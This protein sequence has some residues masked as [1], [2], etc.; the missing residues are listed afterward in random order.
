MTRRS[1]FRFGRQGK[2]LGGGNKRKSYFRGQRGKMDERTV[3]AKALR[4]K[5]M[6]EDLTQEMVPS[7]PPGS[8]TWAFTRLPP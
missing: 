1:H 5:C 6:V 4:Q 7:K 3:S 8:R 2:S